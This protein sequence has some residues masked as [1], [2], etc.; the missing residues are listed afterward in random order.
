MK[1]GIGLWCL[2]S[3]VPRS[4]TQT[5]QDL[6]A[7]AQ[8]AEQVGVHSLWLSEHHGSYHGYCPASLSAAPAALLVTKT[9]QER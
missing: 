6:L 5:Y 7:D 8:L 2:Q 9:L 3:T 4:I 1:I